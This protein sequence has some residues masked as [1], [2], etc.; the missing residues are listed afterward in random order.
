MADKLTDND[1]K[2]SEEEKLRRENEEREDKERKELHAKKEL[3][4]AEKEKER[5]LAPSNPLLPDIKTSQRILVAGFI[6]DAR[7]LMGTVKQ[8]PRK[9]L[10]DIT[11]SIDFPISHM[12]ITLVRFR[13]TTACIHVQFSE[14]PVA[15]PTNFPGFKPEIFMEIG[16]VWKSLQLQWDNPKSLLRTG[17]VTKN[18]LELIS[19]IPF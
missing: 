17:E 13:G 11:K 19:V 6:I 1:D 3:E 10:L 8:L 16:G 15:A 12:K 2:E 14:T 9:L 4:Q 7:L 5:A 18:I